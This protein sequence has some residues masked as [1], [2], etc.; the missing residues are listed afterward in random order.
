MLMKQRKGKGRASKPPPSAAADRG[1]A[2]DDADD[3]DDADDAPPLPET[4]KPPTAPPKKR[5]KFDPLGDTA[6]SRRYAKETLKHDDYRG[7]GL[8]HGNPTA[9][10]QRARK[11]SPPRS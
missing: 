1:A 8:S 6:A 5:G 3:S 7:S 9:R 2:A 11:A 4:A 10:H